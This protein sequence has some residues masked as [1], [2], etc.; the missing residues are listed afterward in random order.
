MP[1]K[2]Q[3]SEKGSYSGWVTCSE[4]QRC[5]FHCWTDATGQLEWPSDLGFKELGTDV[6]PLEGMESQAKGFLNS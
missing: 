5:E 4:L 3:V 1:C 2:R 6:H